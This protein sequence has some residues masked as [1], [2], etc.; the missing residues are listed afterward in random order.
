MGKIVILFDILFMLLLLA[1]QTMFLSS[2][3]VLTE[4]ERD[5]SREMLFILSECAIVIGFKIV[6]CYCV[7]RRLSLETGS[8]LV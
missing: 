8:W 7:T 3:K 4:L 2:I 6:R 5:S 1:H